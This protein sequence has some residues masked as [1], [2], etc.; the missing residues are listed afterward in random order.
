[1][2]P[3][4]CQCARSCEDMWR[5]MFLHRLALTLLLCL[6][7]AQR[8]RVN[9][10]GGSDSEDLEREIVEVSA[11]GLTEEDW[12]T[13]IPTSPGAKVDRELAVLEMFGRLP[14]DQLAGIEALDLVLAAWRLVKPDLNQTHVEELLAPV[15]IAANAAWLTVGPDKPIQLRARALVQAISQHV[16]PA[17]G[18]API[19]TGAG[20]YETYSLPGVLEGGRGHCEGLATL[21]YVVG[22]LI[23]VDIAMVNLPVHTVVQINTSRHLT[24]DAAE[25]TQSI[26]VDPTKGATRSLFKVERMNGL[27]PNAARDGGPYLRPLSRRQLLA[28]QANALAFAVVKQ[29]EQRSGPPPPLSMDQLARVARLV[30]TLD[31][32]RPESLETAA[33]VLSRH[34]D[35][36]SAAA[37]IEH[38]IAQADAFGAPP[39]VIRHYH[40][41]RR[42]VSEARPY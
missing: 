9:P 28:L 31:P 38:A 18:A 12:E 5:T 17:E 16:R 37:H 30:A 32:D 22:D 41:I 20:V 1:M 13:P 3:D 35:H 26:F 19:L 33:V 36:A 27:R 40:K 8:A 10:Y 4:V 2:S 29:H 11:E 6:G 42:E 39:E 21:Y 34:G 25:T 23:N 14:D 7:A 15:V 24:V